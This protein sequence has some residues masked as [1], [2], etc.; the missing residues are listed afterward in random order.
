MAFE[1]LKDQIVDRLKNYWDEFKESPTYERIKDK[2]ISLPA[3]TQKL[4]LWSIGAILA[5]ILI[6]I[7]YSFLSTSSTYVTDFED[8][9]QTLRD[10]Y[11]VQRELAQT[12]DVGTTPE[13]S[14][15][16]SQVQS[17][18]NQAGLA[19]DQITSLNEI[20]IA[21]A[22]PPLIP[23]G[24]GQ[25]GLEISLASLNLKQVLDIGVQLQNSNRSLHILSMDMKAN[26]ENDHYYD[27]IYRLVGF[28]VAESLSR[29]E[30]EDPKEKDE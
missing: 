15:M 21:E 16:R 2:Y 11:R 26:R 27:V 24:V 17:I 29:D 13:P 8:H 19:Q 12:P 28:F 7:P 6:S 25:K 3:S 10:L 30:K 1:D 23:A 22:N 4:V 9:T 14:Q 20:N 5:F 18:L